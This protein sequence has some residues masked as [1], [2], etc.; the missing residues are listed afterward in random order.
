MPAFFGPLVG[1]ALGGFFAWVLGETKAQGRGGPDL[2]APILVSAF[3]LLIYAPQAAYFLVFNPDWAYAYFLEGG[4]RLG[5]LSAGVLLLDVASVPV[6]FALT[7]SRPKATGVS[8]VVRVMGVPLLMVGLLLVVLL[9][10]LSVHATYTQY[11]G[12]F[13]TRPVAGGP[14][15]YALLWT[16]L[17]LL[18]ATAFTARSLRRL[19]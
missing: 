4:R 7:L 1:V 8:A 2:S 11:H 6:G 17:V 9:P 14:L 12:D 3:A 18:G 16:N 19:G 13:G 10:R 5:L 15:G